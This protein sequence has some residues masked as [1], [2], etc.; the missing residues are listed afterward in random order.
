MSMVTDQAHSLPEFLV[1]Q[2]LA[3]EIDSIPDKL[4]FKIGGVITAVYVN[5]GDRVKK[6]QVLA[7]LD[8]SEIQAQV[9]QAKSSYIVLLPFVWR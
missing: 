1:D 4:A 7:R 5:E 6:G 8:P 3:E 9:A 2:R